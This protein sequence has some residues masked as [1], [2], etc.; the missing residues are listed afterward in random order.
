[1]NR[2]LVAGSALLLLLAG[3]PAAAAADPTIVRLAGATRYETAVAVSQYHH[4]TGAAT[5]F[6]AT[7]MAF[8]D[9]LAGAAVAGALDAPLLLTDPVTLPAATLAEVQRLDPDQIVILGGSGAVSADVA[10]ELATVAPVTRLAGAERYATAVAVSQYGF[11]G[12]ATTVVVA[13]GNGFADALAGAPAAVTLGGPLLLTPPDAL[14]AIVAAEIARLQ[15]DSILLLGGLGAVSQAVED[16]L[17]A[18]QPNIT[19]LAGADR[20]GTSVEIS[21]FVFA[22]ADRVYVATGLDFPDALSGATAAAGYGAPILLTNAT[23]LPGA[24]RAEV[25]RLGPDPVIILGGLGVVGLV[26]EH[27][28]AHPTL[29]TLAEIEITLTPME[30][31]PG[32]PTLFDRPLLLLARP[33][34]TRLFVVGEDGEIW[35]IT[36]GG[37]AKT[38]VLDVS[39]LIATGNEQGLLSAAFHP[40]DATRLFICYTAVGTGAITVAEYALPLAAVAVN[41]ADPV[42]PVISVPHPGE[43]NHNGGMILFGPDGYLYLSLGDG[44]GGGDPSNNGQNPNTLLGSILRIDVDTLPYTIPPTNPFP[45]GVGG[46]EE[47]WVYGVRNPWRISFDGADLYVADVGQATREELTLL[48]TAS[49]GSNLGWDILEGTYCHSTG[50]PLCL[51]NPFVPPTL[52]YNNDAT[53]CAITGGYVYRGSAYP[54]LAGTYFYADYCQGNIRALRIYQGAVVDARTFADDPG[55]VPGFGIDTAG[56]VYVTTFSNSGR[57]YRIDQTP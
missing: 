10:D 20:Y 29:P 15:P 34:D 31:S 44:G 7:G 51:A 53:T 45:T 41:P 21:E 27:R 57:V 46:A 56:R 50:S 22:T 55:L 26:P 1:M 32:S 23:S 13:T 17:A 2:G 4:P 48:D 14:P 6:V 47:V 35:S 5:V 24:V 38:Q 33:G 49:G 11:P 40:D 8:P 54:D 37:G 52:E 43:T 36:A 28:L 3:A 30:S 42:T 16:E 9:G 39:S 18:I 12:T 19:R 25:V